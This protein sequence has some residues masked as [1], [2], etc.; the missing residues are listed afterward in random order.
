LSGH[1]AK[2]SLAAG[3]GARPDELKREMAGQTRPVFDW[4]DARAPGFTMPK[5]TGHVLRKTG[6]RSKVNHLP[7][8]GDDP[9]QHQTDISLAMRELYWS[10]SV[11]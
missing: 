11:A 7:L 4:V 1:D 2:I 10:P 6:G 8:P 9:R 3:R 5:P